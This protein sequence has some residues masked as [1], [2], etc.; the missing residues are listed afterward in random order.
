M[1]VAVTG[2]IGEGKSTV[3]E[4]VAA[5]GLTSVSSDVVA[6]SVMEDPSTQ[7]EV[8]ARLGYA[9][10]PSREELRVR[11]GADPAAR[12][13][14]NAITHPRIVQALRRH[15]AQFVEVPLL[16]E[17]C[18]YG[19]FDRVWIVTCG[20]AEQIR[21]LEARYGSNARAEELI[22]TQIPTEAK[23]AF[24]DE[25]I[26]TNR[27]VEIVSQVVAGLIAGLPGA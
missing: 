19:M 12:R 21:R 24:A 7:A 13:T 4:R 11:I 15:P 23:L 18:L 8:A 1:R 22:A 9:V 3:L 6:R 5:A 2:G 10:F 14:L 26:R 27:P 25:V 16:L 20:R 17:A